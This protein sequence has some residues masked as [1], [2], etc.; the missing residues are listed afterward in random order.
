MLTIKVFWAK[1]MLPYLHSGEWQN[2]RGTNC[3]YQIQVTNVTAQSAVSL[4]MYVPVC[5]N[6]LTARDA[7]MR[8]FVWTAVHS[9]GSIDQKTCALILTTSS[10]ASALVNFMSVIV[11]VQSPAYAQPT[12]SASVECLVSVEAQSTMTHTQCQRTGV[13]TT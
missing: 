12:L 5:M 11:T 7:R 13:D 9:D 2:R 6:T 1:P 3:G 4:Q 8:T 10:Y